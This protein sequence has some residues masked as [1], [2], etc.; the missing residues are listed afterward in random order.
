M[1]PSPTKP[2]TSDASTPPR[3]SS[4]PARPGTA[5]SA[6]TKAKKPVAGAHVAWA[7]FVDGMNTM[8]VADAQ[9]L[10]PK[11]IGFQLGPMM[12]EEEFEAYQRSRNGNVRIIR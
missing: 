5:P 9:R 10:K 8:P 6:P 12:T 7:D 2:S 1:E 3:P 11:D 4:P